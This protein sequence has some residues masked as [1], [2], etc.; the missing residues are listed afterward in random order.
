MKNEIDTL[1]TAA[2]AAENTSTVTARSMA[3]NER[4]WAADHELWMVCSFM[5]AARGP[6]AA[7]FVLKEHRTF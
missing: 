3:V 1:M 5:P 2:G 6:H 4:A 7:G